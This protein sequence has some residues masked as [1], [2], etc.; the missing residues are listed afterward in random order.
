MIQNL[1]QSAIEYAS[2]ADASVVCLLG[3]L[4]LAAIGVQSLDLIFLG[5]SLPNRIGKLWNDSRDIKIQSLESRLCWSLKDVSPLRNLTALTSLRIK[6]VPEILVQKERVEM[7]CLVFV[8]LENLALISCSIDS[9]RY[10]TN[11][12]KLR[13]LS[14]SFLKV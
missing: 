9:L 5:C 1:T 3:R 2:F 11:M 13:E 4:E 10:L 7:R 14:I 12:T 6:D 8:Q